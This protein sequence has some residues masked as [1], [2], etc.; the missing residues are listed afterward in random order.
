MNSRGADVQS[1]LGIF[2]DMS[3]EMSVAD[4]D[5]FSDYRRSPSAQEKE[6]EEDDEMSDIRCSCRYRSRLQL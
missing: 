5:E 6:E 4:A 2:D 3:T 1:L